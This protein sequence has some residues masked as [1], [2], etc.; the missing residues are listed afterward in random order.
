M[1]TPIR[2]K[3]SA[4]S[5]KRP[6]LTDLQVGELALNTYD[7]S[8]FTERDTGGVGIATTVSD[9]TPW[10]ESYGASS[11]SYLNSV[12]IGTEIPKSRLEVSGPAAVLTI[13]DTRDQSFSVG[14]VLSS[15]AFDTDDAS[16]G[17]GSASHPRAKINLV[18]ENTFGSATGLSFATK[19]DTGNAPEE[20]IRISSAGLVT[21]KNFNG[22]G[23]KLEGSGGDYQGMQFVTTDSSASQTRN[24]F[25]DVVN[26]T[27]AAIANQV[28]SVQSDG[29]SA[30][31]W[32]T[33]PA[34]N[35]TDRRLERLR[36]DSNGNVGINQSSPTH[37]LEVNGSFA[38]TTKSF[39]IDHPT[40]AVSY[41]HL[42]LPTKRIV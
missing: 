15:L 20:K 31:I 18:T 36:I 35:R 37:K 32:Q 19:A 12:G 4:V 21:I 27:G 40:K 42:T 8:L 14:D 22:V 33:Q 6:Q 11:I 17:A 7:G 38:A 10:T 5:G 3:R 13:T 24:I 29:G 28:G 26:E 30:W 39:V 1:A 16:G 2:I 41:T 23:L 9:L 34:G 25:I